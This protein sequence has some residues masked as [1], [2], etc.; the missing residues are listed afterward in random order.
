MPCSWLEQHHAVVRQKHSCAKE[1]GSEDAEDGRR[2]SVYVSQ[3]C[4]HLGRESIG[5]WYD[6][7][8]ATKLTIP[9]RVLLTFRQ[10][11]VDTSMSQAQFER[12]LNAA[13]PREPQA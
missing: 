5:C 11:A 6:D 12:V 4:C 7:K 13:V 9:S 10:S 2:K 3:R 8:T 1:Q